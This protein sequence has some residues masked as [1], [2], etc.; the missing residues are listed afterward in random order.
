M[1]SIYWVMS[2][3]C[4]RRCP[5]CYGARFRPYV[6]NE[7]SAVIGEEQNAWPAIM[8]NLPDDMSYLDEDGRR[9][10]TLLV[11]AGGEP[12]I[13]GFREELFYP[14]LEGIRKRWDKPPRIS[15]QTT[16]DIM[17]D[18]HIAEMLDRGDG[19]T[20]LRRVT[21]SVERR[22]MATRPR[23]GERSVASDL[24]HQFLR[25]LVWREELPAPWPP[26]QRDRDRARWQRLSLLHQDQDAA[27][28]SDRGAA[29][30]VARRCRARAGD[31]R[32]ERRRPRGNGPHAWLEPRAIPRA[33]RRAKWHGPRDGQCLLWLRRL[34]RRNAD[35]SAR[36]APREAAGRTART[37]ADPASIPVRSA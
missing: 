8:A 29:D 1:Q 5:H 35:R 15:V 22:I 27:R 2:W 19:P 28:Q 20:V 18:R 37:G 34:F 24:C 32:A 26:W 17:T 13:D 16:G 14:L 6:R 30:R 23:L 4:R 31:P 11:L 12:L 9:K 7:L 10:Q 3:A 25:A 33:R 36:R 21:R